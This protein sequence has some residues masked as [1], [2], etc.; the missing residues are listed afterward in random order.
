VLTCNPRGALFTRPAHA[1]RLFVTMQPP[2]VQPS[3]D[4]HP[5]VFQPYAPPAAPPAPAVP[6]T[7]ALPGPAVAL[8]SPNQVALAAFLG[9][10]LGG[11]IVLAL[12]ERRL[13][14]GRAALV[15]V[16]L[17]VLA[18]AVTVGLAFVMPKGVPGA[19]LGLLPL[20]VLRGIA[21]QRQRVFVDAHIAAGGKRASSWAAAGIGLAS[22][23]VVFVPVMVVAVIVAMATS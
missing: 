14:R 20:I 16:L 10:A 21:Q 4:A 11:S 15:S 17:G 7:G 23:A 13:G 12:N 22:I 1:R 2:P 19:P 6:A 18:T 5:A 9:T 8:Y 3:P